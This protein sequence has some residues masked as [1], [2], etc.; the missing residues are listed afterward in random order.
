LGLFYHVDTA[1][2]TSKQQ[3]NPG[4]RILKR[5]SSV[6]LGNPD[7]SGKLLGG[8][9]RYGA[10]EVECSDSSAYVKVPIFP[11]FVDNFPDFSLPI[12]LSYFST[13]CIFF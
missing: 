12:F 2:T 3:T 10:P 1:V 4:H 11:D 6:S 5:V 8:E 7:L 9:S 13:L